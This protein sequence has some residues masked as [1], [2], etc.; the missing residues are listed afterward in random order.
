[1]LFG[2]GVV[3]GMLSLLMAGRF[4]GGAASAGRAP[5]FRLDSHLL[6]PL[7]DSRFLRYLAVLGLVTLAIGPILSF[8]PIFM[9]EKVGLDPG[10]I[11]LLQTGSLIGSLLSSYFWGW[12][13]DRY[14]SKPISMTGLLMTGGLP[15]L[16]LLMPR[17]SP[18]SFAVGLSISFVQGIAS[19]G[20]SIGSGRLLFV[21]IVS[22][23][24][25]TEYLSHYNAWT[26]L[27]S[28][29]GSI[30]GGV[31]LQSF[32]GL[33][34][35]LFRL[36]IDA[37][38]ILFSIGVLAI[39][40]CA[41]L[42]YSLQTQREAG[43]RQFAGMFF[44]G[45]ALM[46]IGSM[47][48]FYYAKQEADVVAA[49]QRLASARSPLTVEELIG[50]LNDPR[51]Y[52]RFE[53][54]V[55]MTRQG[56]DDRLIAAL[57]DVLRA[58]DPALSTMAAW[59]LARFGRGKAAPALRQALVGSPYRSVQIQAARALASMSDHSIVP[60]LEQHIDSPDW[61]IRI[62]SASSLGKLGAT[63]DTP[64]LLALLHESPPPSRKE[65]ALALGRLM[66]AEVR[67]IELTR[68]MDEDRNT[69]LA[70]EMESIR[71]RIRRP[72]LDRAAL[73]QLLQQARD[74]SSR[75]DW[76]T[77][78]GPLLA[79]MALVA[80]APIPAHYR[81]VLEE[82]ARRIAELGAGRPEYLVL[83]VLALERCTGR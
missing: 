76:A 5:L 63:Q 29:I 66:G 60:W 58:P 83:A 21:S 69:A 36:P 74:G 6:A 82:C 44:H 17:S 30:A 9:K 56:P 13:A 53:A 46:A 55:S 64:A 72:G 41:A 54:I 65:A 33:H 31:L 1:L 16:W 39:I 3:F 8:L 18:L 14:G 67:Y 73:S 45:N 34:A 50:L 62:A 42:L 26:G 51:F 2:I 19:S 27:L 37:Y 43:F 32:A 35:S 4:P 70:Q 59:A 57:E 20:W 71:T 49:T 80:A 52:V 79:A 12:L 23:E 78:V 75:G 40:V 38:A 68:A 7:Q 24:N 47:V 25:R 28:G 61:G 81:Q 22:G 11:V 48:R 10:S 77:A 15:V